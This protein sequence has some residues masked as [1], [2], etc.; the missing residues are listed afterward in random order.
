MKIPH[1]FIIYQTEHWVINHRINS[2]LAGY[3]MISAK[4]PCQSLSE[5]STDSLTELGLLQARTESALKELLNPKHLYIA[6]YGHTAG[7]PIHFHVIPV[8][9]WVEDLFWQDQRYRLLE[10]FSDS[11]PET[12]TD[13]AELTLF[14][15]REF[16]ESQTPPANQGL[17]I[18]ETISA[19]RTR[20]IND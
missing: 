3:L 11:V 18:A 6:K 7:Y 10:Q 20:F 16:C 19:L 4:Q 2:A 14:I 15:W 8:C 13:G 1:Q 9:Q 5:L 12:L 17:T